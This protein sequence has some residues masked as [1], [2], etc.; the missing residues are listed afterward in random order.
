MAQWSIGIAALLCGAVIISDLYARRVPNKA[1]LIALCLGAVVL[2][3]QMFTSQST[4]TTALAGLALGLAALLPFHLLGWMGAGDVKFFAV[5]GFLVGPAALLPIWLLSMLLL[6]AHGI[7]AQLWRLTTHWRT[8]LLAV[9]SAAGS[10]RIWQCSER[11]SERLRQAQGTRRG[12]P[13]A[14]HLGLSTLLCL[15]WE[16]WR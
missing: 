3:L 2:L 15:A 4:A 1:L 16:Y 10:Q 7:G 9:G 11:W 8:G 5:L 6:T 12:M 14:A 13:Y